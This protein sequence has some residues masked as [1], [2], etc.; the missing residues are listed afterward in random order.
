MIEVWLI[1]LASTLY[2]VSGYVQ[3]IT[4]T[5]SLVPEVRPTKRVSSTVESRYLEVDGTIFYKFKLPEVQINLHFG[6]FGLIKKVQKR[7]TIV[8]ESNQNVF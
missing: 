3:A 4:Y 1:Q 5:I 6:K 2:L 7:Q 8:G